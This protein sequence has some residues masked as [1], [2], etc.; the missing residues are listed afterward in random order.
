MTSRVKIPPVL[1]CLIYLSYSAPSPPPFSPSLSFLHILSHTSCHIFTE[2][3]S[4][5]IRLRS[6]HLCRN[7]F[8]PLTLRPQ[9]QIGGGRMCM[10]VHD[11]PIEMKN[12][13]QLCFLQ[14]RREEKKKTELMCKE[15]MKRKRAVY[16]QHSHP[17]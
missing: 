12:G 15:K 14:K 8:P 17:P 11:R 13:S 5:L 16:P 1:A 9:C 2:T 4:P 10:G 6:C 3:P 7:I